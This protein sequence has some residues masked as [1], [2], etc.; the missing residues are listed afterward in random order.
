M[1]LILAG[2]L[3]TALAIVLM[4]QVRDGLFQERLDAAMED[5]AAGTLTAQQYFDESETD[6]LLAAGSRA[7][8]TIALLQGSGSAADAVFLAW[9]PETNDSLA[10]INPIGSNN[11]WWEL[12]GGDLR[13][14][15]A[16]TGHQVHQSVAIPGDPPTPGLVVA[17]PV[18]LL[19]SP[20]VLAF[21]YDLGPEAT[22][23]DFIQRVLVAGAGA[24]LLIL[25]GVTLLV[26]R[27]AARPII[28]AAGIA[29]RLTGGDFTERMPVRGDDEFASLA[30][31]FN[32]MADS[33]Q[34]QIERLEQ[35]G[36][37]QRRFV[38]DVSHELRTPLAT[39]RLAGDVVHQARG[40]FP[41][42]VARS[43]ELL[44]TQIE[45]FD[46]LLAD[47]LEISR[48]DAKA[49]ALLADRGDLAAVIRQVLTDLA[50]LA[51][52]R[53]VPIRQH[54]DDSEMLAE[55]DARRIERIARNI[56]GN[57]IEHAEAR[58]VDVYL[59][60]GGGSVALV[61]R[62]HGVGLTADEV[63]H[64]FDRFWRADPARA[65]ATG[66]TGLGLAIARE[67]ARLHGGTLEAWG[68][69]GE[70]ASFRL[71]IPLVAGS[72]VEGEPLPLVPDAVVPDAAVPESEVGE[73]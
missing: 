44:A 28:E 11:E 18:T 9:S 53:G 60:A 5:A 1:T 54:F 43:A 49:A 35:L 19:S 25:V 34:A 33:L 7:Q 48:F 47:L 67:D 62:D 30:T 71:L 65:R 68:A 32:E 58:P 17:A 16:E 26:A 22:T 52:E 29:E 27:R 63:D 64:I 39:I 24:I 2:V 57:A 31:S 13:A 66:G 38:A 51:Q 45:R 50:P 6:S 42:G 41:P 8:A 10:A 46:A 15:A 12:V 4:I 3:I 61:V 73:A 55:F 37:L 70:G 59:A 23:L 69:P 14:E 72:E 21:A 36:R 56:V 40:A 20:Y